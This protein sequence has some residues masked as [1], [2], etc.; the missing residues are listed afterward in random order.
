MGKTR[1]NVLGPVLVLVIAGAAAWFVLPP[2][3]AQSDSLSAD[4]Q[5]GEVT[6]RAVPGSTIPRP[7]VGVPSAPPGQV[8]AVPSGKLPPTLGGPIQ[9]GTTPSVTGLGS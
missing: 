4:P 6:E 2:V 9:P 7:G 1:V 3:L 5:Q 8:P